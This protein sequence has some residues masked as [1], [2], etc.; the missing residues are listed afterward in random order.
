MNIANPIYDT[1]FKFL[2]ENDRIARFF[3]STIINQ[4][5]ESL[6]LTPQEYVHFKA[7]IKTEETEEETKTQKQEKFL[8]VVRYDFM[9]TVRTPEGTKK[10]LIEIQKA[11]NSQ[12]RERFRKYLGGQYQREDTVIVDGKEVKD[13]LPII[14]IYL[15]GFKLP[16][17]NAIVVHVK[18]TYID[19]IGKRNIDERSEFIERLTHDSFVVQ[20]PRIEGKPQT[21]LEKM[22]AVFEQRYFCDDKGIL[23]KFEYEVDDENI[24]LM[25]ETLCYVAADE[26]LREQI[27]IE[28][29]SQDFRFARIRTHSQKQI[30][31]HSVQHCSCW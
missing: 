11:K 27:E 17:I 9:A 4:P 20:I 10:V 29:R 24:R 28:R 18:R 22:L 12:D 19:I 7:Q 14:T 1:V 2:M 15:L 26:K 3:I 5:V 23:K 25:L 16:E 21:I 31:T 30:R 13:F 6:V 8:T